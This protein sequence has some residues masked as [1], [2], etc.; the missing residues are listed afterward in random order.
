MPIFIQTPDSQTRQF[1]EQ[2]YDERYKGRYT[3][4][5]DLNPQSKLHQTLLSQIFVRVQESRN[6]MEKRYDSW[7][8][9]DKTLISYKS[10][11]DEEAEVKS[12]DPNKPVSIVVP[13]TFS[14]RETLLTSYVS[15]FF[16]PP[17]FRYRGI[18]GK[19]PLTAAKQEII[20]DL[21]RYRSK[22][23]LSLYS[24]WSSFLSYGVAFAAPGWMRRYGVGSPRDPVG[25][26][27][28]LWE[29]NSLTTISPYDALPDPNRNVNEI[30]NS[31][32]FGRI[33]HTSL[34]ELLTE[35][36]VDSNMFNCLYLHEMNHLSIFQPQ[37]ESARSRPGD[38]SGSKPVDVIELTMVLIPKDW[39]LGEGVYP[40]KWLFWVA[41]DG[42]IIRAEPLGLFYDEHP[43]VCGAPLFD[44]FSMT[45]TS[46]LERINGMQVFADWLINAYLIGTRRAM[47]INLLVDPYAVNMD[48]LRSDEIVKIIKLNKSHWGR[49]KVSDY[50]HQLKVDNV[51]AENIPGV[52]FLMD[53]VQ[54]VTGVNDILQGVVRSGGER[55]SATEAQNVFASALN[56]VQK[57]AKLVSI[58]AHQDIARMF[59]YN[60]QQ[61]LTK[62]LRL[63]ITGDWH[64]RL[65]HEYGLS[66]ADAPAVG[67]DFVISPDDFLEDFDYNLI[68]YDGSVPGDEDR[69]SWIQLVSPLFANPQAG[70]A[71]GLD[72]QRIFLHV[73]RQLGATDVS[74]FI[75]RPRVAKTD[76]PENIERGVEAGNLRPIE[77]GEEDFFG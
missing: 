57:D 64:N 26:K 49:G 67:T 45:P 10:I 41:G 3:D 11:S 44:D 53:M 60:N 6:E 25:N 5:L 75:L 32:Y 1:S 17:I 51:T 68:S 19:D 52:S 39:D 8:N 69:N 16:K 46:I 73:A 66:E 20:V 58:Q 62:E 23:E 14:I 7:R 63:K 28:L 61:F 70:M 40:E 2:N 48:D 50:I 56:R 38:I 43:I 21:Q 74:D 24:F 76:T 9:I 59:A 71:L 31:E 27:K 42:L 18:E 77:S 72:M 35:E 37:A 4:R 65:M 54:R 22:I 12:K 13:I 34:V 29:G 47:A 55:Q 36:S 30:Q 15:T 33:R